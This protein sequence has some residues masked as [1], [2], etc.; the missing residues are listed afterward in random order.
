MK[1]VFKVDINTSDFLNEY[2]KYGKNSFL[3]PSGFNSISDFVK[4]CKEFPGRNMLV[5]FSF[6]E[7]MWFNLGDTVLL[8]NIYYK[9]TNKTFHANHNII[10]YYLNFE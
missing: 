6:D 9:V 10:S 3:C 2:K 4:G 7:P 5:T 8:N 1:T